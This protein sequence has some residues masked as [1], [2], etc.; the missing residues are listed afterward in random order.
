[1]RACICMH[2]ARTD[3][4]M[5][6]AGGGGAHEVVVGHPLGRAVEQQRRPSRRLGARERRLERR[7]RHA[8]H[9]ALEHGLVARAAAALLGPARGGGG[10]G[11]GGLGGGALLRAC[12]LGVRL[13]QHHLRRLGVRH[14]RELPALVGELLVDRADLDAHA[15]V[16][17]RPRLVAELRQAQRAPV[18][19]VGE[20][21]PR[22]RQLGLVAQLEVSRVVGHRPLPLARAAVRVGARE[23][24]LLVVLLPL[25][26]LAARLDGRGELSAPQRLPRRVERRLLHALLGHLRAEEG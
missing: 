3:G 21:R 13:R 22:R 24:E 14:E 19:G 20:R 4:W 5:Q 26:Q 15:Q 18:E 9:L 16:A 23:V 25:H 2:H 8:P 12:E 10:L 6:R 17:H 1:M 7:D 11:G